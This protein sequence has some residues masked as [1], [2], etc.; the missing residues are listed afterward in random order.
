MPKQLMIFAALALMTPGLMGC[1]SGP[2]KGPDRVALS[3][4]LKKAMGEFKVRTAL[5]VN[6]EGMV[7]ATDDQGKVLERCSVGPVDKGDIQQ[8]RGLQKGATVEHLNSVI[9]VRSKINPT[10]WTYYDSRGY[11]HQYCW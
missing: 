2:E 8:C 11:A 6:D 9:L 7:I 3:D 10:C 1:P 5:L 4:G